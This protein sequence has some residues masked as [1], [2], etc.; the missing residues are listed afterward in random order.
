MRRLT[1]PLLMALGALHVLFAVVAGSADLADIVRGGVGG[2]ASSPDGAEAAFWSLLFGV[3][4]LTGGYQIHWA[5]S[6][7][8]TVPAFP[9]WALVG[10]GLFGAFLAPASPFW[11]VLLLG[12]AVLLQAR[13]GAA[14][15]AAVVAHR[16]R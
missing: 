12:L 1:G 16:P 9:G 5:E 6:R 8:G 7:F 4:A 14:A 11:L 15:A 10:I 2:L 3:L 13:R